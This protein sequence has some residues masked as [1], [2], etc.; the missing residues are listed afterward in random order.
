M[1][2]RIA[3]RPDTTMRELFEALRGISWV[4]GIGQNLIFYGEELCSSFNFK[5]PYKLVG[6]FNFIRLAAC[7]DRLLRHYRIPLLPTPPWKRSLKPTI[8]LFGCQMFHLITTFNVQKGNVFTTSKGD[9]VQPKLSLS[10]NNLSPLNALSSDTLSA[11][12]TLAVISA[13]FPPTMT[14]SSISSPSMSGAGPDASSLA[15]SGGNKVEVVAIVVPSVVGLSLFA[16]AKKKTRN[17]ENVPNVE[18]S[19]RRLS[20]Q[21]SSEKSLSPVPPQ[22]QVSPEELQNAVGRIQEMYAIIR[23]MQRSSSSA[24]DTG[25]VAELQRQ[26]DQRMADNAVRSGEQPP[27]YYSEQGSTVS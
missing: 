13:A 25:R 15:S 8:H 10:T 19:E 26:I 21:S 9:V 7:T 3:M 14:S 24:G 20:V 5:A 18:I 22:S 1:D 11:S 16:T 12:A 4:G 6:F 2:T 27:E 17:P 23:Q